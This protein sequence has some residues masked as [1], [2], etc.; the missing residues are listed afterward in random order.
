[1]NKENPESGP[2]PSATNADEIEAA[3]AQMPKI[4]SFESLARCGDEIWIENN[5]QIYRLR[6]TRQGKLI[7][8]K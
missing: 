7:L 3:K 1:M 2:Q 4:I 6:R 8:T 5:G